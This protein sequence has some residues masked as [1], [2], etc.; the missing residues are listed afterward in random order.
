MTNDYLSI[1]FIKIRCVFIFNGAFLR[2]LKRNRHYIL[3]LQESKR[4]KQDDDSSSSSA[5]KVV[6]S[7]NFTE[8]NV[9]DLMK[10]G[11]AR[12]KCIAELRE[13]NGDVTKATAALLAKS[14]KGPTGK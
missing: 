5:N 14:L 9:A 4:L 13:S 2:V 12:D 11:F 8:Q 7:D 6:E 10:F 1:L 3:T